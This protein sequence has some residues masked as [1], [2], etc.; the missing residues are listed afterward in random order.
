MAGVVSAWPDPSQAED[1]PEKWRLSTAISTRDS[2][3]APGEVNDRMP[4]CITPDGYDD[5]LG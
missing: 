3:V 2:H 1:D 4:A 5:R